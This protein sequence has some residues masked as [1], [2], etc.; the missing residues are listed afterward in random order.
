MRFLLSSKVVKSYCR[1]VLCT[2]FG[3]DSN[4]DFLSEV[5][6]MTTITKEQV[7]RT[8]DLARLDLSEDEA[9]FYS[10]QISSILSFT[11]K[12]NELNTDDVERT[13][14]GVILQNVLRQ[15]EPKEWITREEALKNAPDQEDGQF[16]VPAIL[17]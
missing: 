14:H 10:K 11:E 16:K 13:T 5:N 2:S 3:L 8:A 1:I 12:I 17:E 9:Q 6:S 7:L 15:D 4:G